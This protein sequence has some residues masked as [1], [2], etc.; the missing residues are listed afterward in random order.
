MD[1]EEIAKHKKSGY[2]EIEIIKFYENAQK[3]KNLGCGTLHVYVKNL[4]IDIRGI[5]VKKSKNGYKFFM[6]QKK[7]NQNLDSK[8]RYPIFSFKEPSKTKN[9]MQL[10]TEKGTEFVSRYMERSRQS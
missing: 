10:I 6:P 5:I 8:I 9:L 4:D 7:P 2:M 1:V 3:V